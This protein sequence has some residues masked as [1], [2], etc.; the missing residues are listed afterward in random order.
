MAITITA[1]LKAKT[2][3]EELLRE[4]LIKVISPSRQEAGCIEYILH[5]SIENKNEFV[6]YETWQ[7]EESLLKHIESK[8]YQAYRQGT[9]DLIESRNVYRLEKIVQ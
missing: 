6:F 2:G 3:K 7:D 5:A 4:Q 8:H 1:I 9:E